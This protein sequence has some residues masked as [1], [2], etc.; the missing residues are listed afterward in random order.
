MPKIIIVSNILEPITRRQ[1]ITSFQLRTV[2][3]YFT[4]SFQKLEAENFTLRAMQR[5]KQK[6]GPRASIPAELW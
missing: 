1:S 6:E 3:L 4:Q 2:Q 5:P